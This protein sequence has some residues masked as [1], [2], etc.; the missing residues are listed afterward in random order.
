MPHIRLPLQCTISTATGAQGSGLTPVSV[1]SRGHAIHVNLPRFFFEISVQA[2]SWRQVIVSAF[3]SNRRCNEMKPSK[4][5]SFYFIF[6]RAFCQQLPIAFFLSSSS[7]PAYPYDVALF[8]FFTNKA[9]KPGPV[10]L[11][12]KRFE[13]FLIFDLRVY[14]SVSGRSTK[15]HSTTANTP[16]N[17][18]Y[19]CST[20]KNSSTLKSSECPPP[21]SKM[22]W[23][24][25]GEFSA[26]RTAFFFK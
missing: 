4:V 3:T 5:T 8:F 22:S 12:R 9:F 21:L 7:I 17:H 6:S 26:Q 1:S 19:V 14:V 11:R 16:E 10:F 13:L 2:G 15:V 25:R 23:G 18:T 24:R 20:L